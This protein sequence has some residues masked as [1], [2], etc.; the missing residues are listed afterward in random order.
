MSNDINDGCPSHKSRQNCDKAD[1]GWLIL[2]Y[3]FLFLFN[4]VCFSSSITW[5]T[6]WS[7]LP[8]GIRHCVLIWGF[9]DDTHN[10]ERGT[11]LESSV[12]WQCTK[13][14]PCV[15]SD[16]L[17]Q[18]RTQALATEECRTNER[19]SVQAFSRTHVPALDHWHRARTSWSGA[20]RCFFCDQDKMFGPVYLPHYIRWC[21]GD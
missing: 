13:V 9:S 8:I 7:P 16:T 18:H 17:G 10:L 3:S 11:R 15:S 14:T 1:E 6:S 2:G 19:I 21:H 5:Q 4:Q 20:L 12:T